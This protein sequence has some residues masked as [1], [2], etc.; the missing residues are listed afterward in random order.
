[1]SKD[2]VGNDLKVGQLVRLT[3]SEAGIIGRIMKIQDGGILA[4]GLGV[5]RSVELP[6]RVVIEA[7]AVITLAS[8][9]HPTQ[10]ILVLRDPEKDKQTVTN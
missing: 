6:P 8:G 2:A 5:Q 7:S 9:G 3:L 1:M 10:G 4:P